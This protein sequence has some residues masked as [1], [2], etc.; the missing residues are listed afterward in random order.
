M[1]RKTFSTDNPHTVDIEFHA[2]D[3]AL[4]PAQSRR[5]LRCRTGGRLGGVSILPNG[6][7]L[8]EC[9]ELA[10]PVCGGLRLTVHLNLMEGR[11]VSPAD[12]VPDLVDSSGNL[13]CTFGRLLLR[14]FLP[15]RTRLRSQL[16]TELLAQIRAVQPY[17]PPDT[18]LRLDG[19]AHYHMVPVVFDALMDVIREQGLSV[20]YIRI[21]RE[22]LRVYL[23]H[24]G[25]LCGVPVINLVKVC[26][27]NLL[28]VRSRLRYGD[29]LNTL[30]Q[31]LF[32]GVLFSGQMTRR[33][34]ER[35]LDGACALAARKG[36]GLEILAHPG[37]VYEAEDIAHLTNRADA[38]FLTSPH[39]EQEV[40]LFE[41][42]EHKEL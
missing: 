18:P 25:C 27:L 22:H 5:I 42:D 8:A 21:P 38:A 31:R 29:Y 2:D 24:P 41:I 35:F 11:T 16:R 15:G 33:N 23:R 28:T 36:L 3:F 26:I 13:N 4:F 19:H 30:E 1:D 39:R 37:G 34:V 9:M 32:L 7:F 6:E 40:S 10:A 14:S 12:R 17:L 20:G